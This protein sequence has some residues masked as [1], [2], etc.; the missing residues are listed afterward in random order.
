MGLFSNLLP[1]RN[2]LFELRLEIKDLANVPLVAGAFGTE[3]RFRKTKASLKPTSGAPDG[4]GSGARAAEKG[5]GRESGAVGGSS[6]LIG[7]V[8]LEQEGREGVR[9]VL[10][11]AQA[12]HDLL[13]ISRLADDSDAL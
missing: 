11:P 8:L 12:T 3:W 4:G 5:K 7:L 1:S 13:S 9:R 2:A 10:P 6:S